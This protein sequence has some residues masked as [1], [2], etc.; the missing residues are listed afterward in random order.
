MVQLL[1]LQC[2]STGP[3]P[4]W[5]TKIWHVAWGATPQK[6]PKNRVIKK[7]NENTWAPSQMVCGGTQASCHQ[8]LTGEFVQPSL[9]TA[10]GVGEISVVRWCLNLSL[11]DTSQ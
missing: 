8:E 9:R 11:K 2:S 6:P 5:G 7:K 1:R 4:G 10:S 3:I